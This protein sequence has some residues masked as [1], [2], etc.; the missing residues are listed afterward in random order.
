MCVFAHINII[1]R[2]TNLRAEAPDAMQRFRA[3]F[4]L[5]VLGIQNFQVFYAV[6]GHGNLF[7]P[8][9]N[10]QGQNIR[11]LHGWTLPSIEICN[12]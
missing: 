6:N 4:Y 1:E 5:I 7:P 12:L 11:M 10:K 8:K 9:G 2:I 3:S